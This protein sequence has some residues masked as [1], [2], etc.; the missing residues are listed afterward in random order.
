MFPVIKFY[1]HFG[2][3]LTSTKVN[4]YITTFEIVCIG[5]LR[6][7]KYPPLAQFP[8]TPVMYED[9]LGYPVYVRI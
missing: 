5:L 2:T 7:F 1:R 9:T 3:H 4:A 8:V 6:G